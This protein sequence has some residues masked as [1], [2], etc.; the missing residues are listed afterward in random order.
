MSLLFLFTTLQ[1]QTIPEFTVLKSARAMTIDGKLTEPEWAAA[2]LTAKFVHHTDGSAT[3]LS[4]QAK[5]LWDDQYLYIGFICE[6]PDVWATLTTRDA[7]LWN[8]EV[9]EMICDPDGDGLN[10][11]EAQV[12]P[13]GTLLDLTLTKAYSAGGVANMA[14]TL[15]FK[16]GIWVD[17]TLN[18]SSDVDTKW[19]C[20]VA[21]PFSELAFMGPTLHFPPINGE[22]WRILPTRYDYERKGSK[23]VE[24]SAW[25]QT[26]SSSFHVP[27]RFGR[28]IFSSNPALSVE[29]Q[30]DPSPRTFSITNYPNPFN[31]T[32]TVRYSIPLPAAGHVSDQSTV[33]IKVFD[34]LG[35]EVAT[36]VD[37]KKSAG[38]Y[39]VVWDAKQSPAGIYFCSLIAGTFHD[40]IQMILL[41]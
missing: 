30:H 4:T 18:D 1:G 35:R 2:P 9:V 23:I 29:K 38:T 21:L 31:P 7:S 33:T 25:S 6:D 34:V 8:G 19:C 40:T 12:N 37:E 22:S 24:L 27:S 28:I 41:K 5:F 11:F 26:S 10:Y 14:W 16:A 17:G 3:R 36:L 13:L 20:E 15:N 32:T 39:S